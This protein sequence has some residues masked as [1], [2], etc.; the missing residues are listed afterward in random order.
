MKSSFVYYTC[1]SS[2]LSTALSFT[3]CPLFGPA[4]PPFVLNTNDTNIV[5]A[6][7]NL[8]K[9]FDDLTTTFDGDNGPISPNTT[10]SIALFSTNEGN[11]ADEPSFWE[12]HYTSNA[13]KAQSS[14]NVPDVDENSIYRIG[15]LTEIFTVW[16]LLLTKGDQI[17]NDPILKY[18]PELANASSLTQ[19]KMNPIKYAQ[20]DEITV[21]QLATHMSG[22][23]RDCKSIL[24]QQNPRT[25]Y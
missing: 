16:S 9:S 17:W 19:A 3:P 13:L 15:G 1:F 22:L 25:I 8:T 24:W 18:L 6:L 4:Y 23:A 12:Y 21:G 5:K 14:Q 11:A 2:L 20:W 10:F 7:K